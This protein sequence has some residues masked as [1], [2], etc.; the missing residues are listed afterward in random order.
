MFSHGSD[1]AHHTHCLPLHYTG[2]QFNRFEKTKYLQ[3]EAI[4]VGVKEHLNK[5]DEQRK[6]EIDINHLNVGGWWEAIAYLI[7]NNGYQKLFLKLKPS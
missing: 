5:W 2:N 6:D 7:K 3:F 1:P 4:H